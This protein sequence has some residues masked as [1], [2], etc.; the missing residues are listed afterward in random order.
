MI[1]LARIGLKVACRRGPALRRGR[2]SE[3]RLATVGPPR[4]PCR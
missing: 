4:A 3:I 2:D 1:P